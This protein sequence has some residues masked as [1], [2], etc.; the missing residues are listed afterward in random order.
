MSLANSEGDHCPKV[1]GACAS[2]RAPTPPAAAAA[3]TSWTPSASGLDLAGNAATFYTETDLDS[4][5]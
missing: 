5:F 4:D 2:S 1:K 3:N